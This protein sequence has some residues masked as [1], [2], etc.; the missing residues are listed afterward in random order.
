MIRV[1][2]FD[3]TQQ[4]CLLPSDLMAKYN[5]SHE[6]I[7]RGKPLRDLLFDLASTAHG[8]IEDARAAYKKYQ[9]KLPTR[10]SSNAFLHVVSV[11]YL[12]AFCDS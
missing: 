2:P 10:R 12:L 5:L 11:L 3:A 9:D 6:A 1:V 7:V 8:H 4:K